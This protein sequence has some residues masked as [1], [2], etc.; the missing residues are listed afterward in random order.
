M[1]HGY[2]VSLE[3]YG[4]ENINQSTDEAIH[5]FERVSYDEMQT[6]YDTA[7]IFLN[8]SLHD[9]GCM[10]VL[11]AMAHGLPVICI[12]CGGPGE[13]V[14]SSTGI[15]LEPCSYKRLVSNIADVIENL[16]DDPGKRKKMGIKG[17][18]RAFYEFEYNRKYD[19]FL[20]ILKNH[21]EES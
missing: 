14:N 8:C 17:L 11:E 19:L 1:Q 9:L 16:I 21:I 5:Y 20:N 15:A 4:A 13:L 6:K 18:D 2:D 10:V 12:K 3:I 7:D